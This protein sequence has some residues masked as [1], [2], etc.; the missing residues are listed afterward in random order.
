MELIWELY[1]IDMGM[2]QS[3]GND[4]AIKLDCYRIVWD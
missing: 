1:G 4:M 2:C 3:H